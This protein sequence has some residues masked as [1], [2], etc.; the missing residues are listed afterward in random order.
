[1]CGS[2]S[3][4]NTNTHNSIRLTNN[5]FEKLAKFKKKKKQYIPHQYFHAATI[6]QLEPVIIITCNGT[7]CKKGV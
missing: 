4:S 7:E 2:L 5:M 3:L 1:M 6:P